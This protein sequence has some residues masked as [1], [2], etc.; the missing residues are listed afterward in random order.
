MSAD[1][2]VLLAE[3]DGLRTR[4]RRG[5]VL[6]SAVHHGSRFGTV[7]A[8][9]LAGM[10]VQIDA[11]TLAGWRPETW[12]TMLAAL[13]AVLGGLAAAGSFEQKWRANRA[14]RSSLDQLRIDLLATDA[15]A[16]AARDRLK[17]ILATH[18][19]WITGEG[20]P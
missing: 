8:S 17:E 7:I 14:S 9:A 16:G 18:D 1:R 2:E 3:A 12:T 15:D 4:C 19:R 5:Q 11:E 13:A 20:Q 6:W 10:V